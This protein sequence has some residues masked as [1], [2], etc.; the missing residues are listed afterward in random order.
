MLNYLKMYLPTIM[1]IK[2]RYLFLILFFSI[3][4]EFY[5]QEQDFQTWYI[6]GVSYNISDKLKAGLQNESRFRENS[7][8]MDRNQTDLGVDYMV[9]GNMGIGAYYRFISRDP[10]NEGFST[11]HRFYTEIDYEF[12]PL[13]WEIIPRIRIASDAEDTEGLTDAFQNWIHREKLTVR[14]NIKKTTFTPYIACEVFFPL[15]TYE[16]YLQKYRLFAGFTYKLN[17]SNRIGLSLMRQHRF[18]NSVQSVSTVIMFDYSI[19]LN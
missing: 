17:N 14:Y 9:F 15:Q 7:S 11:Q 3:S 12:K 10:F 6:I 8:I 19:K 1:M 2:M 18:G 13:R 5:A 16:H 4:A